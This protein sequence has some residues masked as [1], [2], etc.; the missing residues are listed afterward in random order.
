MAGWIQ[1]EQIFHAK[2]LKNTELKF[3][4]DKNKFYNYF[5]TCLLRNIHMQQISV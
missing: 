4:I 3:H 1:L 5:C 2:H